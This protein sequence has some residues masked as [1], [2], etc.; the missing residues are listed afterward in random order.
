MLSKIKKGTQHWLHLTAAA[1]RVEAV[2]FL[3]IQSGQRHVR[4][5][6][7]RQLSQSLGV[8]PQNQKVKW[9]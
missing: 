4:V 8:S 5:R 3:M 1:Q 9:S 7:Q 2:R 6:T